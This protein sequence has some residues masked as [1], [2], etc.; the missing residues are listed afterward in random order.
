MSTKSTQTAVSGPGR[1]DVPSGG[2]L[3]SA[4][5]FDAPQRTPRFHD[6]PWGRLREPTGWSLRQLAHRSG[7]NIADLSRIEQGQG[8]PTPDQARRLLAAYDEASAR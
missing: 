5:R 2:D 1:V 6:T 8:C 3:P 4:L 7:V